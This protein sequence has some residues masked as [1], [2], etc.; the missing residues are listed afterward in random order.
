M[1]IR[2]LTKEDTQIYR[3]LRLQALEHSP[4]AFASS[5]EEEVTY[6]PHYFENFLNNQNHIVFG[7]IEEELLV[8]MVT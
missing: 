2:V 7:A 6:E 4:T 3:E 5:Y 8:G 1:R